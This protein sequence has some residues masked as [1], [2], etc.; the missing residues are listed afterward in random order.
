M[1]KWRLLLFIGLIGLLAAIAMPSPNQEANQVFAGPLENGSLVV[2]VY[3]DDLTTA[4]QIAISFEPLESDY[5]KGYLLLAVNAEELAQLEASGLQFEVDEALTAQYAPQNNLAPIVPGIQTISGYSCYRT[6]EETFATAA[7][8]AAN[9]PTLATWSDVGN[10]WE[11]TQS[12]GGYDMQVLK[13]TNS[14]VPGPKPII[15]ITSAIHAR[16]YTTAELTTRL[17]EFLVTNYGTD[18]DATWILDYH[19]V[20]FMLQTNPDGR[21]QAEAGI[22][23]RKNTNQNYCGS[24]SNSRGAD[25]N[26]NFPYNWGCCGGSSG[27]QCSETYRG[28]SAASEPE[29]QAVVN[30]IQSN[31]VD[32][33]GPGDSSMAPLDTEGI[34]LDI[35][36]SGRLLLWPWGHTS[37]PAPNGTQLQTLGRKLAYFNGHSPQ[38]SIGLYPT[39]GTTTSF[40]YGDMGLA[41]F[42]YELGTQFFESCS[43]FENTLIPDNMPSLLY[44]LKVVRAP[45]ITPAGPDA[46]N[47]SLDI[48]STQPGVPSGT[49][50]NL[51]ASIDDGRFNNSNGTEPSQSIAA[52]EYY[53]DAPPWDG[54]TAVP[55]SASD[56]SFNS[57]VEGASATINTTGMS[58]GQ[59]ILYVRGQDANNN[60]GAVSAV[61]L[62]ID[63]NAPPPPSTIFF[64]DFES[65]LGWITNPSGTDTATTGQWERANPEE[66]NSSGVKQLGTT[67]SGNNDLV[68]GPLAGSSVGTHDIDN[69][70]TSIRSPN[71][72]LPTSSD[73]DLSFSYYLAHLNNATSADFLRVSLVSGSTTLLFEELGSGDNDNAVWDEFSADITAFAGQTVYL[74]IEAADASSGS[75]IEAAIDDVRITAADSGPT[76]TPTNTPVPPTPTATATASP[77][78]LP[79]T[80]TATATPTNTPPPPTATPTVGPTSTPTNTPVPPTVTNTPPPTA[81]ATN[82]PVPTA[83]ATATA[84]PTPP[85]GGTIFFDDFESDQG[86]TT[87]PSGSDTATTGQWERANPEDTSSSGPKQLGTTVS[88]SFDLVTGAT[89]GSSVGVNDI[90]NGVTSIRS[91]NISLPTG[92]DLTMTFNYYLAHTSNSSSADFLRITAVGSSSQVVFEELGA[93][94][95]DDGVWDLASVNLNAFAGQTIYLLVEAADA[96]GG[97]IVEAGID[98]VE[99]VAGVAPVCTTYTSSDVPIALPNGTT[100][101]SSQLTISGAATIDDLNVTVDMDHAWVG[102]LSMVLTHQDTGTAVTIIDRPGVPASTYG[103]SGDDILATLDDEAAS[104]VENQCSGTPT[105]NGTFTPNNALSAFDGQSGNGTWQ[106]SVTDSYT[107]ADAGTLNGWSITVCTP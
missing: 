105:I 68:T 62:Y 17:A 60:W 52:A 26:R 24:T 56:G 101:I 16:E 53:L 44:A 41:A 74:L 86:W 39:D 106:L 6:V 57:T 30:Y 50:V 3:F 80:P 95:D 82:T 89:A 12:L 76:P 97:S 69:G 48:G 81:T 32:N 45:Y 94:N 8:L 93:A 61:F 13:L 92:L 46:V 25:L 1:K 98:D 38:Q 104:P 54:G 10:S 20:H 15:F 55:M 21:K 78:P 58:Q 40:A 87:D 2:R 34:Y 42:T 83:T 63:D 96:A 11:K 85:P 47:A 31:F 88:G 35:H 4:R 67:V 91:P 72:V 7:S 33:R 99:I 49:I 28:A 66:T 100:T 18:P 79:P 77:T 84:S 22:L 73:I 64:D 27:S 43:Y 19:E 29:T 36:S 65:D 14:A 103:C 107:S 71:I 37:S 70:V 9:Y 75:L 23:W 102:D 59:H 5:D 90:D 51:S